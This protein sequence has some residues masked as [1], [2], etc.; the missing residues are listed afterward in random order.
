MVETHPCSGDPVSWLL[1][2]EGW[3]VVGPGG[4]VLGTV[5]DVL[6]DEEVD[7]FSGLAVRPGLLGTTRHLPA[8]RVRRI[9]T[10]CIEVDVDAEAFE[11]LDAHAGAGP[12]GEAEERSP[13]P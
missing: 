3:R 6:G 11:R 4:H 1:V 12:G 7:I 10:G 9:T 2:E 13:A 5:H 8:E